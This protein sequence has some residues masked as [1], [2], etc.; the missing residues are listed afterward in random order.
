[1]STGA[2]DNVKTATRRAGIVVSAC[3]RCMEHRSSMCTAG[4]LQDCLCDAAV[5]AYSAVP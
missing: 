2:C 1:M 4:P 5:T 3:G